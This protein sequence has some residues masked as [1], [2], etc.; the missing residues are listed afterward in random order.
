MGADYDRERER[1]RNALPRPPLRLVKSDNNGDVAP[2]Q[3]DGLTES[4]FSEVL[5]CLVG[6]KAAIRAIVQLI[7]IG[8]CPAMAALL[9]R[10]VKTET[11]LLQA[12]PCLKVIDNCDVAPLILSAFLRKITYQK[13]V[14]SLDA[15][16]DNH[17]ARRARMIAARLLQPGQHDAWIIYVRQT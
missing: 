11:E 13:L 9:W 5:M 16:A 17:A 2:V 10:Y 14:A 12:H 7:Y 15:F 3:D 1:L 4:E 6:P 8:V